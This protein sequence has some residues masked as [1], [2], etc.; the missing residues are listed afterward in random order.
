M[1]MYN[2][3]FSVII[4]DILSRCELLTCCNWKAD[5]VLQNM[6]KVIAGTAISSMV[7]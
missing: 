1:I 2:Y 6:K 7:S 4:P 3:L 5:F